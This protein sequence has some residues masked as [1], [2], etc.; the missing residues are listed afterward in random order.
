MLNSWTSKVVPT[1][2]K[3]EF[4]YSDLLSEDEQL[5]K[6]EKIVMTRINMRAQLHR[7]L[8]SKICLKVIKNDHTD[9]NLMNLADVGQIYSTTLKNM[10]SGFI[11]HIVFDPNYQTIIATNLGKIAG[12]ITFR[13]FKNRNFAEII[14]CCVN[15]AVQ[16]KGVGAHMMNKL[17]SYI[18]SINI[19]EIIV[20]A[21]NFAIEFFLRQ[22][23]SP[24]NLNP[25]IYKGY[26]TECDSAMLMNNHIFKEIDYERMHDYL[27]ALSKHFASMLCE[28]TPFKCFIYPVK[29]INGIHIYPA[30]LAK[31][32][33]LVF[34]VYNEIINHERAVLFLMDEP[35]SS[36]DYYK[37]IKNPLNLKIIGRRIKDGKYD[38]LK[39]FINDLSKMFKIIYDNPDICH[40]YIA[41]AR[42]LELHIRHLFTLFPQLDGY[43]LNI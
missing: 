8:S 13:V 4:S 19:D 32:R 2:K 27:Q 21:D 43:E 33:E 42:F 18:Q 1:L 3:L 23:F 16:Q 31:E 20:Y 14:F 7:Q 10:N 38:T 6:P 15:P 17:K 24:I 36:I 30:K 22:G 28:P 41:P 26:I 25:V 12:G 11:T 40:K 34:A 35:K 9:Q 39:E 37:K 29:C 5:V